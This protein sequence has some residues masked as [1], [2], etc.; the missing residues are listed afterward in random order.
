M[1]HEQISQMLWNNIESQLL[2]DLMVPLDRALIKE[3]RH[4]LRSHLNFLLYTLEEQILAE[5]EG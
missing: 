5:L 4:G 1:K 3:L 2:E